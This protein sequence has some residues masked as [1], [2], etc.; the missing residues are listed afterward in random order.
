MA[1]EIKT[2]LPSTK[3]NTMVPIYGAGDDISL[4]KYINEIQKFPILS[5]EQ[6]YEYASKWVKERDN[7]A[8]L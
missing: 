5:A 8:L 6:E 4:A 7:A 2:T 1:K 3:T